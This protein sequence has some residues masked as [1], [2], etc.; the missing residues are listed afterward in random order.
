MHQLNDEEIFLNRSY[1]IPHIKTY[2]QMSC[3][4]QHS[5]EWFILTSHN[6][7]KAAWGEIQN[8]S[9][10]NK[11]RHIIWNSNNEHSSHHNNSNDDDIQHKQP[12]Q[13]QHHQSLFI[14]HWELGVLISPLTMSIDRLMPYNEY[15]LRR[16]TTTNNNNNNDN[17]MQQQIDSK[18]TTSTMPSSQITIATIP[19][20]YQFHPERYQ[21][22]ADIPWAVDL[23]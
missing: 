18:T 13:Q 22:F 5:F 23:H 2:Y 19:L 11:H 1:N 14:R 6:L 10:N 8:I 16:S 17:N 9:K 20:P 15:I 4:N 7:S 3:T 21:Q 12:H